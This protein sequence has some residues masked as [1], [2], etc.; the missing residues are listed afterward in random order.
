[1]SPAE[2]ENIWYTGGIDPRKLSKN[3]VPKLSTKLGAV[4][5]AVKSST[6]QKEKDT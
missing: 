3:Q 4:Q 5:E 6:S 2:I 1:M